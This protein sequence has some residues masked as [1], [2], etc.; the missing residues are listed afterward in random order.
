LEDFGLDGL[1]VDYEY[2]SDHAQAVGYAELLK[3][4]R[5]GLDEHARAKGADYKFLLTVCS[6]DRVASSFLMLARLLRRA[7]LITT[8]S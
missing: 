7:A 3:E 8:R 5:H 1:D 4:L 2:P 6:P